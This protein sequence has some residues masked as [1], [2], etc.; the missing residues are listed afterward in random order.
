VQD[1]LLNADHLELLAL[2]CEREPDPGE[3]ALREEY[4]VRGRRLLEPGEARVQVLEALYRGVAQGGAL[5]MCFEPHHALVA[6]RGADELTVVICYACAQLYVYRGDGDEPVGSGS[7]GPEGSEDVLNAALGQAHTIPPDFI[8][9]RSLDHWAALVRRCLE[10]G[11]IDDDAYDESIE[12]LADAYR[13]SSLP[14]EHREALSALL[15]ERF[16]HD[17]QGVAR[18]VWDAVEDFDTPREARLAALKVFGD[19]ADR[20]PKDEEGRDQLLELVFL[21]LDFAADMP[22]PPEEEEPLEEDL[23][24]VDDD[25]NPIEFAEGEGVVLDFSTDP[26]EHD[27]SPE[28]RAAARAA[29]ARHR[30]IPH[31]VRAE[32]RGN[33]PYAEEVA[34]PAELETLRKLVR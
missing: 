7:I 32:L 23:E 25:G 3:E 34:D 9:G 5:A 17:A 16:P 28:L 14:A 18:D 1:L 4:P 20:V 15:L 33:L 29:F 31:D 12:A 30:W 10:A 6:R 13:R 19:L 8:H 21:V 24:V 2:I 22:E 27:P 26:E 11:R